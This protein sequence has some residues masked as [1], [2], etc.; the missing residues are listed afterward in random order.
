MGACVTA[1]VNYLLIEILP[2][3]YYYLCFLCFLIMF[4]VFAVAMFSNYVPFF[5]QWV[6]FALVTRASNCLIYMITR[7]SNCLIYMILAYW[8]LLP[9]T[10]GVV[11]ITDVVEACKGV[12]IAVM[13]DVMSKNVSIYKS[14]ASSL[15]AHAAANCK[16]FLLNIHFCLS[17]MHVLV[18]ANTN[19]LI[20][21]EFAPSIP[22]KSISCLTR[23]DHNRAFGQIS[24]R[25]SVQVSDVKNVIICGNHSSTQYPD[26]THETVKT[27]AGEKDVKEL[28]ADD[29]W[30]CSTPVCAIWCVRNWSTPIYVIRRVRNWSTPILFRCGRN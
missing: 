23:L 17:F 5:P 20:L 10:P 28:V 18:V 9:L 7:A 25:L 11:A 15:E 1:L 26:V 3:Y 16:D 2:F 13:V 6:Q 27:S 30:N 12:N 24:K 21:K 14:Q 8:F 22:E 19:A 4:L 29:A